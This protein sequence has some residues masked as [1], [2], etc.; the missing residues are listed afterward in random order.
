M[1][2]TAGLKK[3]LTKIVIVAV[4]FVL[5]AGSGTMLGWSWCKRSV[6]KSVI[7]EQGRQ[8]NAIAKIDKRQGR[9]Q[10]KLEAAREGL[11][12]VQD[13]RKCNVLDT[14]VPDDFAN[15]LRKFY[16]TQTR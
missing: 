16:R 2:L 4:I 13:T 10:I 11:R 1:I 5:G 15:R 3:L 7:R 14:P 8:L 9:R 12:N 6:D